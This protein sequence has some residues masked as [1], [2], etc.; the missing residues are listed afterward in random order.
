MQA[1]PVFQFYASSQEQ[2]AYLTLYLFKTKEAMTSVHFSEG[3]SAQ[4]FSRFLGLSEAFST[5]PPLV[6]KSPGRLYNYFNKN[7][8]GR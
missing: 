2:Y 8:P 4:N 6:E 3:N 1:W 7:P 5:M